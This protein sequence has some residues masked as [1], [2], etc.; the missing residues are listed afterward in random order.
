MPEKLTTGLYDKVFTEG[1]H[2]VVEE[3]PSLRAHTE[4]L[5]NHTG[6]RLLSQ[7]LNKLIERALTGQHTKAQVELTN[8]LI[9]IIEK[10]TRGD[11]V[12]QSDFVTNTRLKELVR[13]IQAHTKTQTPRP[14]IPLS[15]SE[16]LTNA[17]NDHR[18]GYEL[19]REIESADQ[20]DVLVAF[21][22][23]SGLR[24][25]REALQD[26]IARGGCL[27]VITTVYMKATEQQAIDELIQMGAKV[28]ISYDIRRTRLHAKA[29]LIRR[30]TGFSTAF[31]GSS[32]LSAAAQLDG[33]EWNVRLSKVDAGRIIDKIETVFNS[34]WEDIEFETYDGS[35]ESQ[36]QLN[37]AVKDELRPGHIISLDVH[38]YPFQQ[39]I[40][41]KLDVERTVHGRTRNLVVAATGTGKTVMAALDYRRLDNHRSPL[42]LLFIAHRKE[43]LE[44][45]RTTFRDALKH[46]SFGEDYVDGSQPQKWDHVFASV[47]SLANF[48]LGKIDKR[49]FGMII[50]D[51]FHHA[52]AKTY[53]RLLEHFQPRYLLGLTA[54]PERADGRDIL[55]WFG[56]RI[57][58]E[59]RVWDAIDRG[60][61]VPFHY[62]GRHDG[63]D[64]SSV[65]WVRG[66]YDD[67]ELSRLF[68]ADDIRVRKIL[69]AVRDHIADPLKM[70]ALGFC[71]SI[72]H[73]EF[74]TRKFNDAG[75]PA[76]CITGKTPKEER[77]NA[78]NLLRKCEVNVLFSVD[79]LGE[80]VDIPPVDTILM[81]RPTSSATVF[82]QQ[83]G[84][85]L[86]FS[87]GKNCLTVLDFISNS[88]RQFRFDHAL[89]AM[90]GGGTR[91]SI[92][93]AVKDDFPALPSGC[94]LQLDQESQEVIL[95]N[96]K[97]QLRSNR[98]E[99]KNL[100]QRLG[101]QAT[102][103]TFLSEAGLS[104]EEFYS[105]KP[106][107]FALL[108]REAGI[109]ILSKGP[110][111]DKIGG[112]LRLL[113][114]ADDASRL[115][116]M[117]RAARGLLNIH[118][119]SERDRRRLLMLVCMLLGREAASD[120]NAGY[121][122]MLDHP[123]IC[124]ELIS[125][126][127]LLA[128]EIAN[129][130][131]EYSVN[132]IVP[133]DLYATYS[134]TEIA[135]AFNLVGNGKLQR[136]K[137]GVKFDEITKCD[138]LFVTIQKSEEYFA[139]ST[140]YGD[141]PINSHLFHWESQN[142][143]K[144]DSKV[145]CRHTDHEALGVTP[146]LFVRVAKK[147]DSGMT[148]PFKFLGPV[149]YQS[150]NGEQPMSIIWKMKYPIPADIARTA[151]LAA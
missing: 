126:T 47:Q 33:L 80:G 3:D 123:A 146:L 108:S 49:H 4:R 20:I 69:K 73:A 147:T 111:E 52:A 122:K 74:M 51:E 82:T 149:S 17:S 40:L 9:R 99:L 27:R 50:V 34:Y 142:R 16:L 59:L 84:R 130:P 11:V 148:M 35:P 101:D 150:H 14:G 116:F 71:V 100:L 8:H 81:L 23:W 132:P 139:R 24:L 12:Q 1:N 87:E 48:D 140:M 104:V 129:V 137:E 88:A 95:N 45:A 107:S 53:Q 124:K 19:K 109:A 72:S 38:P 44:Q 26:F 57:A 31:V 138:L 42:R 18:I 145:G 117:R 29:W 15:H 65:R 22:K 135:G 125:V 127:D 61:L 98:N 58:A 118:E 121:N 39:E 25:V 91:K 85:G 115:N 93:E 36:E 68:T 102:L 97:S 46:N 28:K 86:R 131:S 21:I 94:S 77:K 96:L 79:V 41:D 133:L 37:E 114:H 143:T 106:H 113:I 92:K 63:G 119:L 5:Q 78:Q 62:F 134:R 120:L 10:N 76:A 112:R 67:A 55:S 89:R 75:I 60:L 7:H 2:D 105:K 103:G 30:N 90:L 110:D 141:Y 6:A 13:G 83:L 56:G 128:E 136:P 64:L 70:R 32:N 43:I 54:T 66:K 151:R 144:S